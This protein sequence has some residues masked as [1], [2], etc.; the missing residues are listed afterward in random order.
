VEHFRVDSTHSNAYAEWR[1]MASP[2]KPSPAQY[3][4]LQSAGQLQL[5][6]SPTWLGMQNRSLHLQFGLPRQA[7]SL[8]RIKW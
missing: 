5:L 8:V 4:Q 2:Q 3:Q 7:L 1:A 6:N